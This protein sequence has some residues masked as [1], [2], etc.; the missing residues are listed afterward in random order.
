MTNAG[1]LHGELGW[2]LM[3]L[4]LGHIIMVIIHRKSKADVDVLPRMIPSKKTK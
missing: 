3:A 4:I 2:A 1:N